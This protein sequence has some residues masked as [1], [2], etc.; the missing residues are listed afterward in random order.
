M[1][2]DEAL[3]N[4]SAYLPHFGTSSPHFGPSKRNPRKL[5][6][7]LPGKGEI[8]RFWTPQWVSF[9]VSHV[10]LQV[11][12][13]FSF[14]F[15]SPLLSSCRLGCFLPSQ[16]TRNCSLRMGFLVDLRRRGKPRLQDFSDFL[17]L[18]GFSAQQMENCF[19]LE[20]S[21]L[22]CFRVS[23]QFQMFLAQFH[24]RNAIRNFKT[25]LNSFGFWS[26]SDSDLHE[27]HAWRSLGFCLKSMQCALSPHSPHGSHSPHAQSLFIF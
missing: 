16:Q 3:P 22:C 5:L 21:V 25:Q 9:K 20:I 19:R 18:P 7:L 4:L 11:S 26:F 6:V 14:V 2:N 27:F 23:S 13:C 12:S 17:R 15:L 1:K 8:S 24:V 10:F